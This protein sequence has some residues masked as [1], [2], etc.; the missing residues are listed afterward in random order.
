[1]DQEINLVC[2]CTYRKTKDQKVIQLY[3]MN[4]RV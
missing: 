2:V 4:Q 1:M 3:S